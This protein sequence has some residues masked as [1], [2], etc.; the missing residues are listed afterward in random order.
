MCEINNTKT[1]IMCEI[2]NTKTNYNV[3]D[4]QH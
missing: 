3:W 2:N 4:K 1:N